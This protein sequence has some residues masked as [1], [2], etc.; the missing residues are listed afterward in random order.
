MS[1]M[2]PMLLRIV[3]GRALFVLIFSFVFIHQA[4]AQSSTEIDTVLYAESFELGMNGWS[5]EN[6]VWEA[7][8]PTS[9]PDTTVDGTQVVA[10]ILDG[11]YPSTAN[12]MLVSRELQLRPASSSTTQRLRIHHWYQLSSEDQGR[13]LISTDGGITWEDLPT[14][15]IA[16]ISDGWETVVIPELNN[17]AGEAIQLGFEFVAQGASSSS[18]WYI[19]LV[20][21]LEVRNTPNSVESFE[22]DVIGWDPGSQWEFGIPSSGPMAAFD[23]M[24]VAGTVLGGSYADAGI[25]QLITPSIQVPVLGTNERYKLR[26]WHWFNFGDGDTGSL[27]ISENGGPFMPIDSTF[28]GESRVWTKYIVPNLLDYASAGSEIRLAFNLNTTASGNNNAG[29]YLDHVQTIVIS[30][31]STNK[32]PLPITAVM[33]DLPFNDSSDL[34]E[35]Y[36]DNGVWELGSPSAESGYEGSGIDK[37]A[38]SVLDGTYPNNTESRLIS[39]PF[40]ITTTSFR[41]E[42]DHNFSLSPGDE[43]ILQLSVDNGN[44]IQIGAPFTGESGTPTTRVIN[45]VLERAQNSPRENLRGTVRLGFLLKT[46]LSGPTN[47]G[48]YIGKVSVGASEDPLGV[49]TDEFELPTSTVL[50]QNYPNPFNPTTTLSFELDNAVPV[51][52]TIYDL[53]GRKVDTLVDGTLNSGPHSFSWN[54][55]HMSSGIYLYRLSTPTQTLT[56]QMILFR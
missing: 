30:P 9:G 53:L 32:S 10:T 23:S 24:R 15:I 37:I 28:R 18:G 29:W 55:E 54:A 47:S 20:E 40:E 22:G 11:D 52:L 50:H 27:S 38:G 14:P 5:A 49:N 26:F 19:D 33:E 44:W 45:D 31:D 39:P 6:G 42:L 8:V 48:W 51:T 17:Y 16:G 13:L 21:I 46:Q 36:T 3:T 7:G 41:M 25:N 35:W 43:A 12:S 2:K 34:A 56:K 4:S 1:V